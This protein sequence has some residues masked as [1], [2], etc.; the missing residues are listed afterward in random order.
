[1]SLENQINVLIVDDHQMLIDGLKTL[2]KDVIGI[3]CV[4]EAND[5]KAALAMLSNNVVDLVLLDMQMPKLTG[6]ETARE[7]RKKYPHVKILALSM[8]ENQRHIQQMLKIGAQGY[9]LKNTGRDQLIKSIRQAH[10][11]EIVID[12]KISQ[13]FIRG[14]TENKKTFIP[15]LTRREKEILI[16]IAEEKTTSQIAQQ[17]FITQNAVEYHRKNLFTKFE[18]RN[19]VGLIKEALLKGII[20]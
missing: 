20:E 18:V 2:L 10:Q 12:P 7:I 13:N 4:A 5:G 8:N 15:Q 11:G 17:L 3:R 14:L 19:S 6:L 1:M 9:L 16:L